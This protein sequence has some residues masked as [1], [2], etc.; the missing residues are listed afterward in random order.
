MA[1]TFGEPGRRSRFY[2]ATHAKYIYYIDMF[3]RS[4]SGRGGRETGENAGQE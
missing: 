2:D 4:A 1:L 3:I